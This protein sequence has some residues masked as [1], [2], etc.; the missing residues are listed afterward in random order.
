MAANGIT[1]CQ[2]LQSPV[3]ALYLKLCDT[4]MYISSHSTA[5][6][7]YQMKMERLY[8][9]ENRWPLNP[10]LKEKNVVA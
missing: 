8:E 1:S 7:I 6:E 2:L 9:S 10:R 3:V 5:L 4:C